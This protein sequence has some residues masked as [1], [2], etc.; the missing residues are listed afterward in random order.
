MSSKQEQF[1]T[2]LRDLNATRKQYDA[3]PPI[4]HQARK[5]GAKML[6][7]V[8]KLRNHHQ[9]VFELYGQYYL[10]TMLDEKIQ[11]YRT[12][13]QTQLLSLREV[14]V[15]YA[16]T[17]HPQTAHVSMHRFALHI[18]RETIFTF[19]SHMEY[20]CEKNNQ[21]FGYLRILKMICR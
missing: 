16:T 9:I 2:L 1:H 20:T 12:L 11:E 5:Y 17:H 8:T 18:Q 3:V 6:R 19:S 14:A 4:S 13:F 15:Q 10:E 7:L 21:D